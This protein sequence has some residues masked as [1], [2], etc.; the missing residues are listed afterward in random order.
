MTK[1]KYLII[2]IINCI[3]ISCNDASIEQTTQRPP[4]I[5]FI[6]ADDL[7]IGDVA[8][9]NPE[10]KIP[11]PHLNNLANA[12]M[13]FTDAHT[14]SS[15]CTPT[16]YGIL[17]GRY[18]WRSPIKSGV[19]FGRDSALISSNTAT[20]A[21]LL[22]KAGYH[23]AFIGKWHLGWDWAMDANNE[24]DFTQPIKSGPSELGFDY[25]Y[26]HIASLD[27]PPYVFVEN[28]YATTIPDTMIPATSSYNFYREGWIA[29]DFVMEQV[30]PHFFDKAKEYINQQKKSKN[31]FYLYLP[32][33]SPHTPILP[34]KNW[35]GK[36]GLNPYGDFV[37]E[38][39]HY[40]GQ[41]INQLD[42]LGLSQN[43]MVVFTSDNGCSPMANFDVLAEKG[44]HPSA[45]YRGH[46]ADIYEGGHRVP[47]IVKYP[48]LIQ[49]ARQSDSTICLTDFFATFAQLAQLPLRDEEG[50][51]S[52]SLLGLM[53]D[54]NHLQY[55][56]ETTIHSSIN[57][58]FAIRMGKWKLNLC[59]GSGGWSYPRPEK[60]RED[61]LPAVQLYNLET[62]P[63]EQQNNFNQYPQ[64]VNS[65]YDKLMIIIDQGRST[66]GSKQLNEPNGYGSEWTSFQNL[67][68]LKPYIRSL[69]NDQELP[70]N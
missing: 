14:S 26:G 43:T 54:T 1:E 46:K 63:K 29:P 48:P 13:I 21:T 62:D 49:P 66:P 67:Q 23:T 9:F 10:S 12:G 51:D 2:F 5:I 36:S 53:S 28:R 17:T 32:L 30:T 52:Y 47:T 31:P 44:H 65:L 15:V 35:Q 61:N 45:W 22:K 38:I 68:E 24:I 56:R 55:Q 69:V 37:M 41:L 57:G 34:T 70:A 60:A 8:V 64:I 33:P 25:S 6:L 7:G 27:I 19:L 59:P 11:T 20:T 39:D 58:S 50:V 18:N 4:N 42:S 16:R 3:C 40:V